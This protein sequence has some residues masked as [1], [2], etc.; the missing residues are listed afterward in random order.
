MPCT[1]TSA[2]DILLSPL[3]VGKV[4]SASANVMFVEVEKPVLLCQESVKKYTYPDLKQQGGDNVHQD[5][6]F[7]TL[8]QYQQKP[9]PYPR[10]STLKEVRT[11]PAGLSHTE[12]F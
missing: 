10:G 11:V 4:L 12:Q 5:T 2:P 1:V 6:T 7:A 8:S 9:N 3:L